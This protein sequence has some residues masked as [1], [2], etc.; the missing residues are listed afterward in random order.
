MNDVEYR[1]W[2]ENGLYLCGNDGF[3][4]GPKGR[5]LK[6]SIGPK[7]YLHV[8]ARPRGQRRTEY[9]HVMIC[10]AWHGPRPRGMEAAHED[11]MKSNCRPS[12]LSWKT[13]KENTAD[14]KTHGTYTRG[15]THAPAKLTEVQVREIL[16]ACE[17]GESQS[18]VGRRYGVTQSC[19]SMIVRRI[20][21]SHL[22]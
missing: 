14:R 15:E 22:T 11:G 17:A 16:T 6:R 21:W 10:E 18:K 3:V 12:N 1:P 4:V 9:V 8:N 13:P 20:N 7:G 19:I 5:V 2:P